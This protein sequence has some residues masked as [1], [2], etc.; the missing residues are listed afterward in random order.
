MSHFAAAFNVSAD[1]CDGPHQLT[2]FSS[3]VVAA[4]CVLSRLC[5]V[6]QAPI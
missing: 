5:G 1:I 6:V 3:M 4:V 2:I